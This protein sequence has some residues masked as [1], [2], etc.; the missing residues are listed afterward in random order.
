MGT[1]VPLVVALA[2]ALVA[3][4]GCGGSGDSQSAAEPE[5]TTTAAVG[6]TAPSTAETET[7]TTPKPKPNPTTITIRVVGG[8]PSGGIAR[9]SV[10]RNDRVVLV[11]HSD[12]ADELHL[13]GYSLKMKLAAGKPETWRFAVPTSGRFPL[14]VHEHGGGHGHATLLYLEVHPD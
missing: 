11:V 1:R 6:T 4:A 5:T 8:K 9:P 12:T 14:G 2:T 10:K 7:T 13:H 3:L